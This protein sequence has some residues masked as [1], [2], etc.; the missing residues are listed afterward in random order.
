MATTRNVG[1]L[2]GLGLVALLASGAANDVP[3]HAASLTP[4]IVTLHPRTNQPA[5]I[6]RAAPGRRP[7]STFDDNDRGVLLILLLSAQP[8]R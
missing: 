5:R 6:E 2:A 7:A 8:P 3:K 4:E 1:L